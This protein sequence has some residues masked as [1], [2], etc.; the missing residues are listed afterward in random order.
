MTRREEV[1]QL[2]A[3]IRVLEERARLINEEMGK[4]K[5][6]RSDVIIDGFKNGE[7]LLDLLHP[8]KSG[9]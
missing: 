3:Q 5:D 9:A 2:S 1:L 7:K 6:R 4:L 8:M